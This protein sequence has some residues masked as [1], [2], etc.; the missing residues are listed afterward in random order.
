MEPEFKRWPKTAR[1]N[2]DIIVSEKIDGTNGV[3]YIDPF[4]EKP[5]DVQNIYA[6]S[7]NR[8]LT[9]KT[10]NFGFRAWVI[11]NGQEL[12]KLGPG[13][14]YGEW[15][16][17]GIQRGYLLPAGDRRFSLFNAVRWADKAIRPSCC[18]IVPVM[19][20]GPMDQKRINDCIRYLRIHGS[21]ATPFLNPEGIV[22]F[23]T[24]ANKG[25]KITLKNDEKEKG[26]K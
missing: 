22:V 19:Y 13:Y 24:H 17:H 23:H 6:G 26:E 9:K 11:A 7:R 15:W 4:P 5:G 21:M 2:R 12:F 16:G 20:L 1:F 25:F 3:I 18:G 8:W 10:D 14:H